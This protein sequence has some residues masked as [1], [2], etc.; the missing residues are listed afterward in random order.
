[1]AKSR[2]IKPRGT[3]EE[4][5]LRHVEKT[6]CCWLWRGARTKPAGYG[7]IGRGAAKDGMGLVHRVAL[8]LKLGRRL[9]EGAWACH[10]CPGLAPCCAE[11]D[12]RLCVHPEHLY[13]GSAQSNREDTIARGR[14]VIGDHHGARNGQA[15]LDDA[16]VRE[17]KR[18]IALGQSDAVIAADFEVVPATVWWI[19]KGV[20]WTHVQL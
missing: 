11:A 6:D 12:N 13:E 8:E 14:V 7:V 19:R 17:I 1:M 10:R 2:G 20:R 3:L 18:R 16:R 9:R 15:K 5:L 4:R